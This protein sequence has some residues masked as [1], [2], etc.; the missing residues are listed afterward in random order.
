MSFGADGIFGEART[1][2]WYE[3]ALSHRDDQILRLAVASPGF[4]RLP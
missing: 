2:D 4:Q 1:P 3:L